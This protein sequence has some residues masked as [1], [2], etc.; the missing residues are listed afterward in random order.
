MS[1]LAEDLRSGEWVRRNEA[2]VRQDAADVGLRI[3]IADF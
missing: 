3:V 2:L 1:H